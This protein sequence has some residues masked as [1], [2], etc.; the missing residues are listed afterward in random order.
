[1]LRTLDHAGDL[2]SKRVIL[3]C[4]LNVPLSDGVIQ[5]DGRIRASV[6][7]IKRLVE[8]GARVIVCSHLGRPD[9]EPNPKYSLAPVAER[10][11]QLLGQPVV[12]AN[13]TIG[14]Q[15]TAAV[16]M[17]EDGGVALIENLRF[18][19]AETS[20]DASER[21]EFAQGLAELGEV[22]VS[23]GF[24]VVHRKQASVFELAELVPSFAGDL[25]ASELGVLERLTTNPARPYTVVLGGSKVSDKLGV[26]E[27]LLPKVNRLVIGGGMVFTILKAKGY[28]VGKS[29]LE[30]DQVETVA[31]FLNQAEQLGVEVVL[32]TDIVIA[33]GFSKDAEYRV[34]PVS[35][36]E[37]SD[38]GAEVMGLD[39]GPDSAAAFASAVS[40]SKTVF[41]NG[42]MGVFEFPNFANGTKVL[43]Q[44][45]TEVDGLSV[46][47]GGDSASAV[48]A[49]GFAESAFG[50][51]STGGGASLEYLEGKTLPG[52]EV[53]N[54]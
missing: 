8:A 13:D 45:L 12:F 23:D 32:P 36:I 17:L 3:R 51:I 41:W 7:T 38:L 25:I 24:G 47:G 6:P 37:S 35:E 15:A 9:G 39:I 40:E 49:L 33:S 34:V 20:K 46:V 4:D 14:V 29:L 22:L 28:A 18:N 44:A 2:R 5:D 21:S 10:L 48:R 53:L 11:E 43:A 30:I 31:N 19:A 52:L 27:N 50:H 42:P 1:M 54:D 26:I 16:K